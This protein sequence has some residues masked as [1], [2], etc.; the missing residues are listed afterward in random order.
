MTDV[1]EIIKGL[2]CHNHY[3]CDDCPYRY[4]V[5]CSAVLSIDAQKSMEQMLNQITDTKS[6]KLCANNNLCD[7]D[8]YYLAKCRG[9]EKKNW[10]WKGV[11]LQ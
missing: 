3:N 9:S 2:N 8:Y 7:S 4:T 1:E 10:K 6:C 11:D 5:E